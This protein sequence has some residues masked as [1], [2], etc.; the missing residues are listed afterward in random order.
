MT[1]PAPTDHDWHPLGLAQHGVWLDTLL[2]ADP[3]AY[4]VATTLRVHAPLDVATLRAA[5]EALVADHE[6][7]RLRID[8]D[9]PRQRIAPPTDAFLLTDLAAADALDAHLA[10]AM[11]Q[12][13]P[14]GDAALFRIEAIRIAPDDW[15]IQ[16]AAHHLICD[17][18][19]MAMLE[20]A[21]TEHYDRLAGRPVARPPLAASGIV[22]GIAD[23]QAY[24][25]SP[26]IDADLA[27]WRTRMTPL[28]ALAF[29]DDPAIDTGGEG[30]PPLV[31]APDRYAAIAAAARTLATTPHRI[32]VAVAGI[33][34][35]RRAGHDDIAIGMALHGREP[36]TMNAVGMFARM[37]PIRCTLRPGATLADT[38][39]AI[40]TG[41]DADLR[42]A[43]L[44]ID[45]LGRDLGLAAQ[46]RLHLFDAAVTIMPWLG[47]AAEPTLA[48][49][50]IG[51]PTSAKRETTPLSFY[52][53]ETVDGGMTIAFGFTPERLGGAE[54]ARIADRFDAILKRLCERPATKLSALS[55]LTPGEAQAI[56]RFV[57]GRT[58]PI[59]AG[60]ALDRFAA[61][62]A[63][64]PDGIA[65]ID[66]EGTLDYAAL[67]ARATRL[68]M[69][70]VAAGVAPGAI[71]AVALDRSPASVA[72]ILAIAR[73]GAVYLP[74]DP[75]H[76]PVRI[77]TMLAASGARLAI[78]RMDAAACLPADLPRL[79][80]DRDDGV[81]ATLPP[82]PTA[83]DPAYVIFTSG[84]T[85]VPKGVVV[86][87]RA[88][89]NLDV[90]RQDHDPIGPGDRVLAAISVGFDVSIGQLLLPLLR[91]AAI[92][93]A[94]DL[95]TLAAADFWAF[96]ADHR[97]THVNSVPSF[98]NAMLDAAPA[99][100]RLARLMLGGE[101]LSAALADKLRT[102]L[103]GTPIINVYGPTEAC[104]DASVYP[105][106][107]DLDSAVAALPIGRPLPNYALHILDAAGAS[108]GIGH[109]GELHIGGPSLATGYLGAPALTADR[110][111]E[112]DHGRL[113]RTG[114]LAAWREDGQIAFLGRVDGQVKIRGHRIE[115]GE[116]EAMLR[117]HPAVAQA[118]V[119][120]RPDARGLLRLLGYVVVDTGVDPAQ[121]TAH[122]AAGLPDYMVPAAILP[123]PALPLTTNGKLDARALPDPAHEASSGGPP[124][125]PTEILVAGLFA[126]LLGITAVGREDD[127][128]RLGGHSLVATQ[129]ATRLR[130]RHALAVPIRTLFEAPTVAGFATRLDSLG[131]SD[132]ARPPL[133]HADARP[134]T[135]PLS[136]A[137]ERLWFT[138]RMM[139]GTALYNMPLL[140]RVEGAI[141][142]QRL[143]DA[144][145]AL[146]ARHPALRTQ[147]AE[148]DGVASQHVEPAGPM[149]FTVV[150]LSHAAAETVEARAMAEALRP[151][152]LGTAPLCRFTLLRLADERHLAIFVVHHIVADGWSMGVLLAE[153]GALYAGAG[154]ALPPLDIDY[155]DYALWQREL[156]AGPELD[157]QIAFWTRELAD[158]PALL[159][160]PTDR[161]RP[162]E[163][164]H[165]GGLHPVVLPPA[166]AARIAAFAHDRHASVFTV[167]IAAW[168]ATL[169]RWSGQDD[170]VVGTA[171]AGRRGR[172]GSCGRFGHRAVPRRAGGRD[173][174]RAGRVQDRRR[175]G[176]GPRPCR[177]ARRDAD[178]RVPARPHHQRHRLPRPAAPE[179]AHARRCARQL[180]RRHRRPRH[181]HRPDRRRPDP[182]A[183][184]RRPAARGDEAPAR[185]RRSPPVRAPRRAGDRDPPRSGGDGAA[186]HQRGYA[187]DDRPRR[188]DRRHRPQPRQAGGW[189]ESGEH[190][191]A[192]ARIR[193]AGPRPAAQPAHPDRYRRHDHARRDRHARFRRGAA[194]DH[195]HGPAPP[196]RDRIRSVSG[197]RIR[198]CHRRDPR[199][200]G[201]AQPAR[202]HRHRRARQPARD[203][204][205]VHLARARLP[206]RGR[207]ALP[208]A[209]A[210]ARQSVAP[211]GDPV[212]AAA[213][214]DRRVPRAA[215]RR[216]RAQPALADRHPDADRPR[217]EEFHPDR[218]SRHAVRTRRRR[219]PARDRRRLSRTCPP[220]RDD[221][222]RDGGRHDPDRARTGSGR[223]VPPADGD[224]RH[225]RPR[226]LDPGVAGDRPGRLSAGGAAERTRRDRGLSRR[227][228]DVSRSRRRRD[229]SGAMRHRHGRSPDARSGHPATTSAAGGP[230]RAPVS[231]RS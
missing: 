158:A 200:A 29:D 188:D 10:A 183:G 124:V 81:H 115:T 155:G 106:P 102:R 36:A 210:A 150:D 132:A 128:F 22:A 16:I 61:Q 23:D 174:L 215:A 63:A 221:Q 72:A 85:G 103:N 55:P 113:Y 88:L 39:K 15:C 145:D 177:P 153:L 8:A 203:G 41:I 40:T 17:G 138:D 143:A 217:R 218:R 77:A 134:G 211:R 133:V 175:R 159:A 100:A 54:V 66:A 204:A 171:M 7:L 207:I 228:P 69:R 18:V 129:V 94:P 141:D 126:E 50:T 95:R 21:W 53:R 190:P 149:P 70:L 27:Y 44:P 227:A 201:D 82:P 222:R 86:P 43:R 130:D 65:L 56:D 4:R 42:H 114:D 6:A 224:L 58:V 97:V 169:A 104:I 161:P 11:R 78:T 154:D 118:A 122:V 47:D 163:Q 230:R 148:R 83:G 13:F 89:V 136:F 31:I 107:A 119:I 79:D 223:G 46:G 60:T 140:F 167:L 151:F 112:T 71:V 226:Y 152:D 209:R 123:L 26:A 195:A 52:M 90:A 68:A 131:A 64:T 162:P 3:A 146:L 189:R 93:V 205:I 192:P 116:I 186:R 33:A 157:R 216:V 202:R 80:V 30:P 198:R 184:D 20:G 225:R 231:I 147:F 173:C 84:S 164:S 35:A 229:A 76:P 92:V 45:R 191:P 165:R 37:I 34:L 160:L 125:T 208:A 170:L 19:S 1:A 193:P 32:L 176:R 111:V 98:L 108:V 75:A 166:L 182:V 172:H 9:R 179:A 12:G 144:L 121:L 139:P 197:R 51:H 219:P 28:P 137:Q 74:I 57:R 168:T 178:D 99:D 67:D 24:A 96:L 25:A 2:L 135:L 59:P 73:A 214:V 220:D 109:V 196:D 199:A 110:F 156:L 187:G 14:L 101:P 38:A 212:R 49:A 48:G 185:D 5:T 105:V 117:R 91:G 127:F 181:R 142:L 180:P 206:D 62:V 213:G 87:H 194:Q 120:A